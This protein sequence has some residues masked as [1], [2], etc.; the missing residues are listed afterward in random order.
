MVTP[1]LP[2][3]PHIGGLLLPPGVPSVV[4]NGQPAAIATGLAVCLGSPPASILRGSLTVKI[5]GLSAARVGDPTSHGGLISV[6]SPN[7]FIGDSGA[8][9]GGAAGASSVQV[10]LLGAAE[11]ALGELLHA[12]IRLAERMEKGMQQ[13]LKPVGEAAKIVERAAE[14]VEQGAAAGAKE[15]GHAL[16]GAA[17]AAGEPEKGMVQEPGPG[18]S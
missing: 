15:A 3:V 7:V 17:E 1:G 12:Q 11:V 9:G 2:P 4:I 16:A 18:K 5:A 10:G 8:A 14:R 6:G 13:S